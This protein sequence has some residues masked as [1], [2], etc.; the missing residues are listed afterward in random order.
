MAMIFVNRESQSLGQFTDQEISNGLESGQFLPSDLGWQEGMETWQPLSAF[1]KL[2]PPGAVVS[3]RHEP[4]SVFGA[5]A[6]FQQPGLIRYD[7]CLGKAWEC[8]KT[9]WGLCVV[10]TLILFAISTAL[11]LPMQFAQRLFT[12]FAGHGAAPQIGML[13]IA[14]VVFLFFYV[15]ATGV[16][17]I[18]SAGFMLFFIET[19]R[20]KKAELANVFIG[21]RNSNWVQLLLAMLVWI[22]AVF[23]VAAVLLVPG[24]FLTAKLH[25]QVPVLVSS[26]LLLI[27]VVYF[28]IGI[29]FVFPLIVDKKLGF[30]EAIVTSLKTVHRQW[31]RAFGL[32]ILVALVA[33]VGV[34]ACCVGLLASAPFA[35]LV[36]GQ[37]Y[38]QLF[39]DGD[40]KSQS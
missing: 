2:P 38:R 32:M 30:W 39:G 26:A 18:L 20:T 14:G 19:L 7:E 35:Y 24:I 6:D 1:T 40:L 27:P 29:G 17:S 9:N 3:P 21:F 16:S 11:Q 4:P 37:A 28:S 34:L 12:N 33:F 36:W 8:F 22:V 5:A 31:F 25:S 23:V 15:L 10:A 13:A